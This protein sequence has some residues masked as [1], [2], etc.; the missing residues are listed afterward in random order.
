[1]ILY[2]KNSTSL[3]LKKLVPVVN[4]RTSN[5]ENKL[6]YNFKIYKNAKLS[7]RSYVYSSYTMG[8]SICCIIWYY[9]HHCWLDGIL[10]C[11]VDFLTRV[12]T[13]VYT[14]ATQRQSPVSFVVSQIREKRR[15]KIDPRIFYSDGDLPHLGTISNYSRDKCS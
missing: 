3:N 9:L 13:T 8:L 12:S 5:K 11:C 6:Y 14:V 4:I 10:S 1:M 7:K 15:H 2:K